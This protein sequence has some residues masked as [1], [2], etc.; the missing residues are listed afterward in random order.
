MSRLVH[1]LYS[2]RKL[3]FMTLHCPLPR[4]SFPRDSSA[5]HRREVILHECDREP[6]P[7]P[8]VC[9]G[10][11]RSTSS[12][13]ANRQNRCFGSG[14]KPVLASV[15]P[16]LSVPYVPIYVAKSPGEEARLAQQ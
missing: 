14:L 16:A 11:L 6:G 1:F 3:G 10:T 12:S 8:V 7:N 5:S 15:P 9:A 13:S 4:R 2:S